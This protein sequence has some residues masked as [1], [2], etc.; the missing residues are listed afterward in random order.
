VVCERRKPGT[1][2]YRRIELEADN[3]DDARDEAAELLTHPAAVGCAE[4]EE[5]LM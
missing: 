2:A 1:K 3:E 5:R 4:G